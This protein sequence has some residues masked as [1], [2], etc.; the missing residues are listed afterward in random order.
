MVVLVGEN[1]LRSHWFHFLVWWLGCLR[2]R[3]TDCTFVTH[4]RLYFLYSLCRCWLFLRRAVPGWWFV[5]KNA[6][7][8]IAIHDFDQGQMLVVWFAHID[9]D[10]SAELVIRSLG[11]PRPTILVGYY[12]KVL[13]GFSVL[14]PVRIIRTWIHP[15]GVFE[16]AIWANVASLIL[17]LQKGT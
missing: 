12:L 1:Q 6:W 11:L 7:W 16:F 3:P 8:G 2:H 17:K 5:P 14:R 13:L 15:W 4:G 10:L 9:L